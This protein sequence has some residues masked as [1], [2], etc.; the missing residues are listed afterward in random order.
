MALPAI[1]ALRMVGADL[2]GRRRP[3]VTR[4]AVAP[5][6]HVVRDEIRSARQ[7]VHSDGGPFCSDPLRRHEVTRGTIG[8]DVALE[9]NR[10][11][12]LEWGVSSH[13]LVTGGVTLEAGLELRMR[14]ERGEGTEARYPPPLLMTPVACR[15][16]ELVSGEPVRHTR[17]RA[18]VGAEPPQHVQRAR[19]AAEV[20]GEIRG[21]RQVARIRA[22]DSRFGRERGA[23]SDFR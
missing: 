7:R 9:A 15:L 23:R 18:R 5:S 14:C 13:E 1:L 11:T 8:I 17:R 2:H 16:D 3:S 20:V 10:Y 12:R 19:V 6:L 4:G 21:Y 22:E